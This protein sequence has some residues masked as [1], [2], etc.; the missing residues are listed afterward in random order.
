MAFFRRLFRLGTEKKK[1]RRYEHVRRDVNPEDAWLVLGELGD[2]AFGKVFKAQNKVTG[3]L[4]AA[5]VIATPSEEE[6]EDYVVEIDILACCDHPNI[7]KLLDALYWDG[8]LWILVEFCAGGAVDAAILELEKGLTEE[9]IR[10]ACKQ[11]LLA[12]QYLHGCK[13]IHRDVKAGNVLLTLDGDVKLADFGV[14]AKNSSTFQRRASFIGTPYWMAPEVVQCETSKENPY[15]YKADIWSLGITLIEMAEM[16]PPHHDLNPLRVLLKIAKSQPPTLRHPK[17]WSEDFKDFLRKSLEKSPEARW[18]AS[19][20]L[21]HPFVADVCDKR[22]LRELVAE[23]RADVLEEF[24]EEEE[25]QALPPRQEHGDS[26]CLPSPGEPERSL[27]ATNDGAAPPCPAA[28]EGQGPAVAAAPIAPH[29]DTQ[30]STEQAGRPHEGQDAHP[31]VQEEPGQSIPHLRP[32]KVSDLLKQARRKSS[33]ILTGS[34]RL[35]PK[36]PSEFLKLMRRRSFF[37]GFKS[38]E[39]VS[40]QRGA[41]GGELSGEQP[42]EHL[43]SGPGRMALDALQGTPDHMEVGEGVKGCRE[44][45][46]ALESPSKTAELLPGKSHAGDTAEM[47][48]QKVEQ[49]GPM[50]EGQQTAAAAQTNPTLPPKSGTEEQ[51]REHTT[52]N[53]LALPQDRVDGGWI[54]SSSAEMLDNAPVPIPGRWA[55]S[56]ERRRKTRSLVEKQHL[57][58]ACGSR[59][60]ATRCAMGG[61]QLVAALDLGHVRTKAQGFEESVAELRHGFTGSLLE[62]KD[63]GVK[64]QTEVGSSMA[65]EWEDG[66]GKGRH[67]AE[68]APKGPEGDGEPGE[69]D[70]GQERVPPGETL[71]MQSAIEEVAVGSEELEGWQETPDGQG[72]TGEGNNGEKNTAAHESTTN[73]LELTEQD[74]EEEAA[75]TM[76]TSHLGE[77]DQC[78]VVETSP[79]GTLV[80]AEVN[81]EDV[82]EC[83]PG[84]RNPAGDAV[85]EEELPAGERL[86]ADCAVQ[87]KEGLVSE[88]AQNSTEDSSPEEILG[89]VK[90]EMEEKVEN[91]SR[92]KQLLAGYSNACE[93]Q[94][95]NGEEEKEERNLLGDHGVKVAPAP[96][97]PS[98]DKFGGEMGDLGNGAVPEPQKPCG[99]HPKATKTVSFAALRRT[100]SCVAWRVGDIPD[101]PSGNSSTQERGEEPLPQVNPADTQAPSPSVEEAQQEPPSLRRTVKK[102]RRFVVDGEEVSVTTAKT[103]SKAE[104]REK[105]RSARR[106]ELR[107]L[108]VLQKEEQRAQSQLEQ[109]FHQQRE[110]MFRHIEQEMTSKKQYYDRE[111]ETLERH[112]RQLK[113]RQEL[114]Y[115][116]KLRDDAKRLKSLQEKDG[117]KRMQELKGN[118]TEEQRFLQRQQEEL[119][120][121]LQ[122][123][124]QEHKKKMMSVDWECISKIHSLRRA[125]ESVVWSMEQGH[126]QEKY[127]LFR[128]QV[129]EQHALQRQ[130]L[131]KRHEKET[132]RLNRFHHLL[133][134]ELRSQQTHERAQLLKSQRCDAK[135]RLALFKGNLKIQEVNGAEQ[136]ERAKQFLQQEDKRQR[137]EAQQQREQHAQQLQQLQ[138]QQAENLVELEQMQSEKM[139]LL[140]D[141]ERRQLARLDG[142]HAMELSE[143]K[144]RLAA[145]KEML[146]EELGNSL[147]AQQRGGPHGTRSGRISRFFHLPS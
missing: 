127:Q 99:G 71:L 105:M 143:W 39:V 128:Q 44:E 67:G 76:T 66:P 78:S 93:K 13:I 22:P 18:S 34:V 142:E 141:Q 90:E 4:A 33:P 91:G 55:I 117:E 124:V 50:A 37:G 12:L 1:P 116:V 73:S 144:Q 87:A 26:L 35:P 42:P 108:R 140:A 7:I 46:N 53:L 49:V 47:Q 118:K 38:H 125:R 122:R 10:A 31:G 61:S 16:E 119:N 19:Q 94:D 75:D 57:D 123:V 97:G 27:S 130:Q 58:R 132:E 3:A 103:V 129:K 83:L 113:E 107:E 30:D 60:H 65:G 111:V 98:R 146:E 101:P 68:R 110:Q 114:E 115:T 96:T 135:A 74:G 137:A 51:A 14:S 62:L 24:E 79:K 64:L 131:R 104:T 59:P 145:R 8:Q 80:L 88:E 36:R 25:E 120:A 102:T 147:P 70:P 95:G 2:G 139:H 43:L 56:A 121:A 9:Q 85:G 86:E 41:D 72:E 82:R 48:E 11:L 134:E 28:G 45:P 69:T 138:Q 126:L 23:A 106:E 29:G 54:K 15:G 100:S 81:S 5:K 6:L 21:Q 40:E 63:A 133:L 17:R 92:E 84:D 20:L 77:D 52:C 32:K 109:K 112:Y 136:R 89:P